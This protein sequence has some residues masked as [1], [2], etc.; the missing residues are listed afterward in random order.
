MDFQKLFVEMTENCEYDDIWD[1]DILKSAVTSGQN[2][3]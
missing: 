1:D 2:P 3:L